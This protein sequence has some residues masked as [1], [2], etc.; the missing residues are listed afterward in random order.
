[1]SFACAA[2][3]EPHAALITLLNIR[4]R[5]ALE[6]AAQSLEAAAPPLPIHESIV[7]VVGRG[8]SDPDSNSEVARTARL[9]FEN[10]S[11]LGVEYAYQAVARPTIA[12]GVTR[13]AR[14]GARQLIVAPYLLFTGWVE[15]EIRAQA[16]QT[17]GALNLPVIYAR[18]LGV[19]PMLVDV[20][21]ERAAQA[22]VGS[23]AMTCDVCKYRLPMAGY[24]QQ[25]G[26]TPHSHHCDHE[27]H[28]H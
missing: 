16:S 21:V 3:F 22:L 18:P 13:A 19:H 11:Y 26:Q 9:L 5:E 15:N 7:L 10:R 28:E 14:L 20:A 2:P 4:V 1:V 25:V 8:S 12:E 17:A 23:A 6:A 27:V 24:E